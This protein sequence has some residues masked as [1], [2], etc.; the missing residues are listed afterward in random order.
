MTVSANTQTA[1]GHRP[2][3]DLIRAV[4]VMLVVALHYAGQAR[5]LIPG[6]DIGVN[7]FFV[8][9]GFLITRL[10]LEERARTGRVDIAA[11]MWRRAARLLPALALLVAWIVIAEFV[12]GVYGDRSGVTR[13]LLATVFYARNW[14]TVAGAGEPAL[15]MAWSLS[16]EE[17]FYLVWPFVF[18][19]VARRWGSRTTGLVAAGVLAVALMQTAVRS[20]V[21]DHSVEMLK[22]STDSN[23][24][25]GL[26]AG[27]LLAF[28]LNV[29]PLD[30]GRQ[31][32]LLRVA[33]LASVAVLGVFVFV[34]DA[35]N[36]LLPAGGW[37]AVAGATAVL[38]ACSLAGF[39][40]QAGARR[41][42]LRWIGLHS[43]GIYLWHLP[44]LVA[45]L[46]FAPDL[47]HLGTRVVALGATLLVSM[48]S[49][50]L[51]EAPA[52]AR[53]LRRRVRPATVD[54]TERID[55]RTPVAKA[56]VARSDR[57]VEV[58]S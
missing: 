13:G 41:R 8:L 26:M 18:A 54:V 28:H 1:M 7:V 29:R 17:Q 48:L 43:Y 30:V 16:V 37:A 21:F 14:L 4:A 9:S 57:T 38:I 34:V 35:A 36:P 11:F 50:R 6:G 40:A 20:I 15:G 24:L 32:T 22:F 31:R 19:A 10:L 27:C 2:A 42:V 23:G 55:V 45:T 12:F 25:I 52:R 5:H 49:M 3:L 51:V 44:A 46:H 47:G 39:S 33:G 58:R 53:I 56:D